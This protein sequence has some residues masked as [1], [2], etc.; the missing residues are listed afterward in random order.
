MPVLD[1]ANLILLTHGLNIS[2]SDRDP[3]QASRDLPPHTNAKILV[4]AAERRAG[5]DA[6]SG[7][8]H[9]ILAIRQTVAHPSNAEEGVHP[10][11][12]SHAKFNAIDCAKT[13]VEFCWLRNA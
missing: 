13:R 10:A 2:R 3:L 5:R 8:Y 11:S 1:Y 9:E 4:F 12:G 6:D 7:I